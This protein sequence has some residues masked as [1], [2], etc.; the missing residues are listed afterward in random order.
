MYSNTTT[1]SFNPFFIVGSNSMVPTFQVG[2]IIVIN[3]Q[4]KAVPFESLKIGDIIAFKNQFN[5]DIQG[6]EITMTHRILKINRTTDSGIV[7]RT[8]GDNNPTSIQE[9]DYPIYKQNYVGKVVYIIPKLGIIWW[10]LTYPP[11]I[12]GIIAA[13]LIPSLYFFVFRNM[14]KEKKTL[15][16]D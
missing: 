6:H 15:P 3:Q 8:K 14:K 4:Q 11:N 1:G 16:S 7:I 9:I 2:D 5:K 10:R 13:A 12:F